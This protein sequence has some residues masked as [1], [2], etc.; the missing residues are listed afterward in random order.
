[1]NKRDFVRYGSEV[2][3][4]GLSRVTV[5]WG[6]NSQIVSYVVNYCAHGISISIPALLSP[7]ELPNEKDTIMV[8]MP[9]DQRWFTGICIYAR[10]ES[11][12]SVS[13]GID[14][15]YPE[16][17]KYLKDLLFNALNAPSELHSFVSYEWEE[18]VEKMC[19]SEDLQLKKVG[20]HHLAIIKAKQEKEKTSVSQGL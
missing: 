2:L 3:P 8:L 15:C 5:S 17:Q 13:I 18:L 19:D 10:N 14:F 4:E 11:N 1:M 9:V 12:G 20:Y 6:G 16:E 7:S